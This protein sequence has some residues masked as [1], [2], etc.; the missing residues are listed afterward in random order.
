MTE[1]EPSKTWEKIMEE[2]SATAT[3]DLPWSVPEETIEIGPTTPFGAPPPPPPPAESPPRRWGRSFLAPLLAALLGAGVGTGVTFVALDDGS[4]PLPNRVVVESR[5]GSL[6]AVAAVAKAVLPSIVRIDV[7]AGFE[8][9]TGSG[10]IYRQDGYILTNNHVVEGSRNITVTLS[11][12]EELAAEVVGTAAPQVDIAVLKVNRTGLPAATLGDTHEVEVGDLAVA[13]GSPFGLQ[14]TV[15][16]GV[17]SA[18]HR[19]ISFGQGA[20]FSDAI[21]TDAPINPG[22]SGGALANSEG[23]VVGINTAIVPG[24]GGNVGVG[25]AIPIEIAKR[26][27]DQIISTGRAQLPFLGISGQ[28][29]PEDRGALI[30]EIVS[31][32]PAGRAGLREG[33][34]IVALDGQTI[35]SMD[36][37]ISTLIQKQVGQIVRI[38]Y[39]RD[40]DRR[41]A[42]ARLAA[43][44]EGS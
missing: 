4:S 12:G 34:I 39:E 38:T 7:D 30:Q 6:E 10:V 27:A 19:N 24:A 25:F 2:N 1:R 17:I 9:G 29:L 21:Q 3:R 42:E 37:L 16:A 8:S 23:K 35:H 41:T 36:E 43:R 40:G 18:L 20:R 14:G 13:L 28:N 26:V 33:D 11:N 22:N 5:G 44:P 32:G 15:T 31:G